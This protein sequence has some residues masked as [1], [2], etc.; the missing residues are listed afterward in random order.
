MT[1][2]EFAVEVRNRC[3]TIMVAGHQGRPERCG[4]LAAELSTLAG[5]MVKQL[6]AESSNT[7][8]APDSYDL[9][10]LTIEENPEPGE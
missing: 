8:D 1:P 5:Q 2:L 10:A 7:P 3:Q 4:E 6:K 9:K